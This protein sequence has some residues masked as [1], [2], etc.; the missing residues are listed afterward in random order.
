MWKPERKMKMG[1][2]IS[3]EKEQGG[4]DAQQPVGTVGMEATVGKEESV[5]GCS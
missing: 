4:E 1:V 5:P 3:R 2:E